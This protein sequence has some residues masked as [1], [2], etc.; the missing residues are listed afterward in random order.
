MLTNV[1]RA[2]R[3][4]NPDSWA[5][6]VAFKLSLVGITTNTLLLVS[7]PHINDRLRREGH[8]AFHNTTLG[9]LSVEVA[10]AC[11]GDRTV[12]PDFHQGH[13]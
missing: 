1:A 10:R 8:S 7:I 6:V 13:A 3:K 11:S 5:N 12:V 9:G 4:T 2:Q